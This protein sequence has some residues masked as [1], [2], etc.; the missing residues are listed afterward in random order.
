M[1]HKSTN[2][3]ITVKKTIQETS[4]HRS[5]IFERPRDFEYESGD[6]IDI[7]S[8]SKELKGCQT[9]SLV[10]FKL[11]SSTTLEANV[12]KQLETYKKSN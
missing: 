12:I 6:W 3:L 2:I 8:L 7:K 1:L 11:A 9:Y 10:E 4:G 5:I